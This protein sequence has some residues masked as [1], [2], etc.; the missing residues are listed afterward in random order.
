M[1]KSLRISAPVIPQIATV[2]REYPKN[3]TK[4]LKL[5]PVV[6]TAYITRPGDPI[7]AVNFVMNVVS[8]FGSLL[9]I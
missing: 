2:I 4:V 8:N 3:S 9:P 5:N 1:F 6:V 7:F